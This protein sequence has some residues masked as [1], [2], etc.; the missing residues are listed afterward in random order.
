MRVFRALN[1]VAALNR[2][3]QNTVSSWKFLFKCHSFVKGCRRFF[4]AL[5]RL[6]KKSGMQSRF[7]AFLE[8]HCFL[9]LIFLRPWKEYFLLG[10]RLAL[11]AVRPFR[12]A[13]EIFHGAR[14]Y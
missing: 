13:L 2:V 6:E 8:K 1:F 4:F 12:A 5:L 10:H 11:Q 3:R 7:F 14:A 9:G